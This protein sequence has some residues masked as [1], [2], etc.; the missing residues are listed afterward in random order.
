MPFMNINYKQSQFE[1]FPGTTGG[2]SDIAKPRY[3]FANLT[4]SIENV[5]IIGIITLMSMVF[6]FS[7]GV[8]KGKKVKN[9]SSVRQPLPVVTKEVVVAAALPAPEKAA[10]LNSS[11]KTPTASAPLA[12]IN[13]T[14]KNSVAAGAPPANSLRVKETFSLPSSSNKPYT[15][16]VASFKDDQYAQKEASVLKNKNLD[17]FVIAKGNFFIVCIGKFSKKEEA[18]GLLSKLKRTYNDC[19]VRRF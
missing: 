18:N 15:I 3:L 10:T 6:A 16:Q 14:K 4:L 7:L 9:S 8:E 19:L 17:S 2:S 12:Q 5:V 13:Q 11:V 1:L